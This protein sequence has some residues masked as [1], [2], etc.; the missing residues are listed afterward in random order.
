MLLGALGPASQASYADSQRV[1]AAAAA[2]ETGLKGAV[3]RLAV[4][5]TDQIDRYGAC[6]FLTDKCVLPRV[7]RGVRAR[8]ATR[9]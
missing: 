3:M 1:L 5:A 8:A 2:H 9:G 6:Y 7:Q 4:S